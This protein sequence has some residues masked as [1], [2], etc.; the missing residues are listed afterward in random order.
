MSELR[1]DTCRASTDGKHVV[2]TRCGKI[3]VEHINNGIRYID[4]ICRRCGRSGNA[5]PIVLDFD[6]VKWQ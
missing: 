1:E 3:T 2:D 4:V 5:G 6:K